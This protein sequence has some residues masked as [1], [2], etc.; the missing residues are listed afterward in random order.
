MTGTDTGLAL[1]HIHAL[2]DT[3]VTATMTH[4]EDAPGHRAC[5][6]YK[7]SQ[8]ASSKPSSNSNKTALKYHDKKYKRVTID[9]PPS[10]YYSSDDPS[11]DSDKDLN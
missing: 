8:T 3:E 5:T 10:D 1:D 2:I 11:S 4:T 9:D 7:A 6:L